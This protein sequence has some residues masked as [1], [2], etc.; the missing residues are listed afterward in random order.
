MIVDRAEEFF[1]QWTIN[2]VISH[3]LHQLLT[4]VNGWPAKPDNPATGNQSAH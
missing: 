3:L 4:I 1:E 2:G